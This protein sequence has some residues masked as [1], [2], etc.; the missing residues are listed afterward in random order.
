MKKIFKYL[1]C[2]FVFTFSLVACGGNN[3]SSN[4]SVN[5]PSSSEVVKTKHTVQFYVEDEL[6]KTLKSSNE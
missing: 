3:T 1:I 4:N 2:L 5:T 6:Y